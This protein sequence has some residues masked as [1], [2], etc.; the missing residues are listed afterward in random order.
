MEGQTYDKNQVS[1]N[2]WN[3]HRHTDTL[4]LTFTFFAVYSMG[5]S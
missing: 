4:A 5:A 1:V 2:V 3:T